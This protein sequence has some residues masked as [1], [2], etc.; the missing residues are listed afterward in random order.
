MVK[1]NV[2]EKG[3][4]KSLPRTLRSSVVK[5]LNP[6]GTPQPAPTANRPA[7]SRVRCVISHSIHVDFFCET[8]QNVHKK[9]SKDSS[10]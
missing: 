5:A 2:E 7:G 4:I 1:P 8:C 9:T 3:T 6:K 10:D